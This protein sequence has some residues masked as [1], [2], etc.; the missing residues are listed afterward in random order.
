[1]TTTQ[2]TPLGLPGKPQTFV[3]KAPAGANNWYIDWINGNDA[4]GDGS[5]GNPFKTLGQALDSCA[6]GDRIWV[7][8]QDGA[9]YLERGLSSSKSNLRISPQLGHSPIFSPA[10]LYESWTATGG[11]TNVFETSYTLT[12]ILGVWNGAIQLTSVASVAACD[13]LTNSYFFDNPGNL[14]HVNVGGGAPAGIYCSRNTQRVVDFSGNGIIFEDM[15]IQWGTGAIRFDGDSCR[16]DGV[17]I[18]YIQGTSS[19]Q[20]VVSVNGSD[21]LLRNLT[22]TIQ[23]AVG[24]RGGSGADNLTIRDCVIVRDFGN[25]AG[26]GIYFEGG[27][28]HVMENVTITGGNEAGVRCRGTGTFT[29]VVVKNFGR[30]GFYSDQ[31]G[32]MTCIRCEAYL[33]SDTDATESFGFVADEDTLPANLACYHCVAAN[34]ERNDRPPVSGPTGFGCN[35]SGNFVIKNCI[36]WNNYRGFANTG[37]FSPATFTVT[38]NCAFANYVANYIGFSPDASNLSVDPGFLDEPHDD[39]SLAATSLCIDAGVAIPGVNDDYYGYAPDIGA[40]EYVPTVAGV[41]GGGGIGL[42]LAVLDGPRGHVLADWSFA[43][44]ALQVAEGGHGYESM[45]AEIIMSRLQALRWARRRRLMWAR[46][47]SGAV[48]IWEGRVEDMGASDYGLKIQ[49]FGLWRQF[50]DWVYTRAWSAVG[51]GRWRAATAD[52]GADYL[53]DRF[54]IDNNNRI[55]IAPREGETFD[56]GVVG[57]LVI[58]SPAGGLMGWRAFECDYIFIAPT[59]WRM[60]ITADATVIFALDSSGVDLTGAFATT[61][62]ESTTVAVR[63]FY[64]S[65]TPTTMAVNTGDSYLRISN[66]RIASTPALVVDTTLTADVTAPGSQAVTPASMVNIYVGQKLRVFGSFYSETIIVTAITTTTFTAVFAQTHTAGDSVTAIGVGAETVLADMLE[67]HGDETWLAAGQTFVD[68]PAGTL[69]IDDGW[70]ED[71]RQSDVLLELAERL[72]G[73]WRVGV[74]PWQMVFLRQLTGGRAWVVDVDD[75]NLQQSVAGLVNE[76]YGLYQNGNGRRLV[77]ATVRDEASVARHGF[78]RQGLIDSRGMSEGSAND[79]RDDL[80]DAKSAPPPRLSFAVVRVRTAVGGATAAKWQVRVGDTVTIANVPAALLVGGT[81]I[82]S[83]TVGRVLFDVVKNNLVI[84][85]ETPPVLVA[86]RV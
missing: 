60:E 72:G 45:S 71:M 86:V 78:L 20:T 68:V 14:L 16:L 12:A 50:S 2:Y 53:P 51:Y 40:Y 34:I 22:M 6:D 81:D 64:N 32:D 21:C 37:S 42:Q 73:R 79:L 5:S 9:V 7:R 30:I 19:A 8:A 27:V 63:M 55:Y 69:D 4:T 59:G 25:N 23:G 35:T 76:A 74:G 52:D 83:F 75:L 67:Q 38:Y 28:G 57:A 49:G 29:R 1:M 15:P 58:E 56:D 39:Y 10:D 17:T 3:A 41:P 84:E 24:I 26:E 47:S 44:R 65:G 54:E 77:T 13:A 31:G 46:V 18:R 43:V 33:V 70:W 66:Y 11:T 61:F 48:V 82:F 80:L 62:D 36:S 85:P